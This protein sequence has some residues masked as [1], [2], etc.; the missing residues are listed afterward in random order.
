[1]KK[2][3]ALLGLVLLAGLYANATKRPAAPEDLYAKQSAEEMMTAAVQ[4]VRAEYCPMTDAVVL[5]VAA[6]VDRAIERFGQYD[7]ANRARQVHEDLKGRMTVDEF[8]AR[9]EPKPI[10]VTQASPPNDGAQC[11]KVDGTPEPCE[12]RR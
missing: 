3:I 11:L 5:E 7:V 6:S 4:L 8:C 9:L 12:N 10:A 1:M 2:L